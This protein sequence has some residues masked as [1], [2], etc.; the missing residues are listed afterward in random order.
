MRGLCV[1]T[2]RY[3]TYIQYKN[4]HEK[5]MKQ[6]FFSC[7]T[8]VIKLSSQLNID[9]QQLKKIYLDDAIF[10]LKTPLTLIN[11]IKQNDINDPILRQVLPTLAEKSN[12]AIFSHDPLKEQEHSPLPGVIHKYDGRVLLLVTTKCPINCRFCF[13]RHSRKQINDWEKVFAY[14]EDKKIKEVILSGGDPLTIADEELKT[15]ILRLEQI[16]SLQRIR[17]HSRIPIV[18]PE[19]ISKN[20]LKIKNTRLKMVMVVHCN[21]PQEI[22]H[23]VAVAASKLKNN[24]LIMFSQT[25]LLKNINDSPSVL[26]N[27]MEKLFLLGVQPYYLHLLD[28]VAGAESFFVDDDVA[29]KILWEMMQKLPGY[30]VPKLVRDD[31]NFPAKI[32]IA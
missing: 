6:K 27:L 5:L 18:A 1:S 25:V 7:I 23:S 13:R 28:K 8:D 11:R 15:L 30:L 3:V 29:K 21:H 12:L 17:I 20:T 2:K 16:S 4:Y 14:L 19:R 9:E 22:D 32:I 26:I 24:N 10:P 31:P